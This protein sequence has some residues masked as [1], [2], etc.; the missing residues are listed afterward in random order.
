MSPTTYSKLT[1]PDTGEH[2]F[3]DYTRW[4]LLSNDGGRH[5][6]H[7]LRTD[8]EVARLLSASSIEA[9]S[10]TQ[11]WSAKSTLFFPVYRIR[12]DGDLQSE[13]LFEV[14]HDSNLACLGTDD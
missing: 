1:L 5:T 8:E 12:R 7:Y 14:S 9:A 3:T 2:P 6:W 11:E 10:L 13:V 4:R